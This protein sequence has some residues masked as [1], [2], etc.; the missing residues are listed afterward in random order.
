VTHDTAQPDFP[1]RAEEAAQQADLAALKARYPGVQ[2]WRG[3]Y[4]RHWWAL[5]GGRLFEGHT[6]S[7]VGQLIGRLYPPTPP[8]P[9]QPPQGWQHPPGQQPH[10]GT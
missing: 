1:A 5:Y 7:H 9:Q 3:P 6:P 2:V 4:T 10:R 8:Q